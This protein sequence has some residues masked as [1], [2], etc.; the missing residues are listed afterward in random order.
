M[1]DHHLLTTYSRPL[2]L[3]CS[4]QGFARE[5]SH[6]RTIVRFLAVT[7]L[8]LAVSCS[9]KQFT[10]Y[11]SEIFDEIPLTQSETKTIALKNHFGDSVQKILGIG[12]SA[13]SNKEGN[14][15]ISRVLVSSRPVGLKDITVPPESSLNI[16][17]TYEPRNLQ[18][19][20][21]NYN[22]WAT[23]A[24]ARFVPYRPGASP[25]IS[26]NNQAIHRAVLLVVYAEPQEGVQEI[27]LMGKAVAGPGGETALPEEGGGPCKAEASTACFVGKFSF[28]IPK[29]FATGPM[30]L[31][32]SGPVRF[33]I[34]GD[35]VQL[36][37]DDFPFVLVPI[38]GNGPGQ[39][40]EGQPVDS[41]SIV[42]SGERGIL[43]TGTFD[44]T[45]IDLN[46]VAFRIRVVVGE[47]KKEDV[48]AGLN[49]IVDFNLEKLHMSTSD[50]FISGKI[51]LSIDTKLPATPSGNPIFDKFLGNAEINV[52]MPGE[53]QLP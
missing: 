47:I 27:E 43:A 19:T 18:T 3:S 8:S 32:L 23:G 42:I 6:D 39:P 10:T 24:P 21:A 4:R 13:G 38:K 22:G 46:D 52:K 34:S 9:G 11:D 7:L 50:P 41:V 36:R 45:H 17:I 15:R 29:M 25:P 44:G 14:F 26:D 31:D 30:E 51:T 2:V 49:P 37:M 53:L 28:N 35:Q 12:F 20:A 33:S 5:R 1:R 16:E 40:L 48:T